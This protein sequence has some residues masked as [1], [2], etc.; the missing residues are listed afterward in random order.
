M[1]RLGESQAG[2]LMSQGAWSPAE[3][4]GDLPAQPV[5]PWPTRHARDHCQPR[6]AG[7]MTSPQAHT[8]SEPQDVILVGNWDFADMMKVRLEM[9]VSWT[10]VGPKSEAMCPFPRQKRRKHT[11]RPHED[12]GRD[13]M[14]QPQAEERLEP[15]EATRGR[16][17][18]PLE[19]PRGAWPRPHLDSGL[20]LQTERMGFCR[21]QPPSSWE[22]VRQQ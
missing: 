22:L 16:K 4:A 17:D 10:Q 15:P 12:G 21:S 3:E 5:G 2:A 18:P 7:C 1:A 14:M 8:P 13:W 11:Q 9:R 19:P 6:A 20:W